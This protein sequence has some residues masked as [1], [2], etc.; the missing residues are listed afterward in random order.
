[1]GFKR[2]SHQPRLNTENRVGCALI[3]AAALGVTIQNS[4]EIKVAAS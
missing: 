3:L 1:M 4:K 2:C